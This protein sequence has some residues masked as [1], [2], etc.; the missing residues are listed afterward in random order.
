MRARDL[1]RNQLY[2]AVSWKADGSLADHSN[3][4]QEHWQL[5]VVTAVL[6]L[7]VRVDGKAES[8]RFHDV[9]PQGSGGGAE[10]WNR[11]DEHV[12]GLIEQVRQL[13]IGKLELTSEHVVLSQWRR[14]VTHLYNASHPKSVGGW[15]DQ[16][17]AD[18]FA[19]P[20]YVL[21]A[22]LYLDQDE[23]LIGGWTGVVAGPPH[24]IGLDWSGT[25]AVLKDGMVVAPRSGRLLVFSGGGENFHAPLPVVHGERRHIQLWFHCRC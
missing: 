11:A 1:G 17:H 19:N 21:S 13:L 16:W 6:P 25:T 5:G 22:L 23:D 24:D 18:Y 20:E 12:L 8:R 3:V 14:Q 15:P 9:W 2:R 7:L 4:H 10:D